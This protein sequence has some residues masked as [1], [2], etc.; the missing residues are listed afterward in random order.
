MAEMD[1]QQ[2]A[3]NG[4]PPCFAELEDED[5]YYCGRAE[6]WEGHNGEHRFVSLADLL[7]TVRREEREAVLGKLQ[8]QVDD[9]R[10]GCEH[11]N[12]D[13]RDVDRLV[14]AAASE[15]KD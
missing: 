13:P 9:I 3:L 7:T 14:E 10:A 8:K 6:R 1:W 11:G 4:G 5:G 12:L 15:G 2:V